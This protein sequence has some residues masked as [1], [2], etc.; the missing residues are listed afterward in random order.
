MASTWLQLVL[1]WLQ[2]Y[3]TE[4]LKNKSHVSVSGCEAAPQGRR[5]C[6]KHDCTCNKTSCATLASE[7]K[8]RPKRSSPFRSNLCTD[9]MN[10]QTKQKPSRFW[11]CNP[12]FSSLVILLRPHIL[13]FSFLS[14]PL[15]YSYTG[16]LKSQFSC[17]CPCRS[18]QSIICC[19]NS[20]CSDKPLKKCFYCVS[21]VSDGRNAHVW[22]CLKI[23]T[24]KT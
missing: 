19:S 16:Q 20:S 3:T 8:W 1:P 2:F 21:G 13:F 17:F 14:W 18:K 23:S 6:L 4:Q 22:S 24:K 10:I 5:Q 9:W 11:L 15:I 7:Q 12:C